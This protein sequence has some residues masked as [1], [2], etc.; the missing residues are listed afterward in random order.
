VQRAQQ[1]WIRMGIGAAA[2]AAGT[3]GRRAA[4][5]TQQQQQQQQ[6]QARLGMY[7]CSVSWG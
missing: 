7:N 4:A 2:A 5:T 1:K 6:R 3:L